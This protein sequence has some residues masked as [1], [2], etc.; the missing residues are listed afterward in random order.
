VVKVLS[1]ICLHLRFVSPNLP[2][3]KFS[4][5]L[6]PLVSTMHAHSLA[7]REIQYVDTHNFLWS[8]RTHCTLGSTR[9]YRWHGAEYGHSRQLCTSQFRWCCIVPVAALSWLPGNFTHY[10]RNKIPRVSIAW[11]SGTRGGKSSLSVAFGEELHSGIEASPN[12]IESARGRSSSPSATLGRREVLG[13]EK[14][15]LTAQT[16]GVIVKH[17]SPSAFP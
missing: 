14:W 7:F 8:I 5:Q 11:H 6:Q 4:D 2:P 12:A 9:S 3:A 16:D 13:N 15:Y 1:V 10:G 17:S